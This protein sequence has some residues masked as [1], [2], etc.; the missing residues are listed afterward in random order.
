M[1][2]E[3]VTVSSQTEAVATVRGSAYA[4]TEVASFMSAGLDS[5]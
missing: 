2:E 5:L 3:V 4:L 1:K